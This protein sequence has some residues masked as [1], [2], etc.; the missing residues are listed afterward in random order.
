MSPT[1]RRLLR[2]L[3]SR[4]AGLAATEANR[5]RAEQWTRLNALDS[6]VPPLVLTHLWP[7]A[8]E[9]VLPETEYLCTD[10]VARRHE[11]YLRQEL[12][13]A[14][15]L[16]HDDVLEPVIHFPLTAWVEPFGGLQVQQR[17]AD[18]AQTGAA[19]FVPVIVEKRDLEK[20]RDPVL[21]M[22]PGPTSA[23]SWRRRGYSRE[24]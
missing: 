20:R 3:A 22:D 21:H 1:D 7:L 12:W 23:R 24:Y 2:D 10:P 17:W 15:A 4:V 6:S 13:M 14:E 19:E 9:E 5:L 11:R 8:W 18:E 16:A